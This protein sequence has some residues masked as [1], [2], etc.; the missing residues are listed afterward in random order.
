MFGPAIH[1]RS[2]I[3]GYSRLECDSAE[4]YIPLLQR[5]ACKAE[6]TASNV[7][8]VLD[9]RTACCLQAFQQI[10]SFQHIMMLRHFEHKAVHRN[11][12]A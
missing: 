1:F 9:L 5:Q 10:R 6:I 12:S 3:E 2:G 7:F 11:L 8:Y 4:Q